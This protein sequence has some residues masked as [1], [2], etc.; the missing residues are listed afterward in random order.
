MVELTLYNE[1]DTLGNL[2]QHY[3]LEN[4]NDIYFSAYHRTHPLENQITFV[5]VPFPEVEPEEVVERVTDSLIELL[6]DIKTQFQ[7]VVPS[8]S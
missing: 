6:T 1:T 2:L 4:E 5:F 7:N 3:F 8:S